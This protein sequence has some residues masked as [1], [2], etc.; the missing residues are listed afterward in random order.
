MVCSAIRD[1][2]TKPK[3]SPAVD[4]SGDGT[5]PGSASDLKSPLRRRPWSSAG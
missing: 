2:G 1:T 3:P 5:Y 4:G